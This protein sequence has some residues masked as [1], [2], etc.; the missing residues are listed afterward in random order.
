[1]NY[2]SYQP[3]GNG[4]RPLPRPSSSGTLSGGSTLEPV[5]KRARL[6][7]SPIPPIVYPPS[8]QP[9]LVQPYHVQQPYGV[10][11]M[12]QPFARNQ[13]SPEPSY[14]EPVQAPK[15]QQKPVEDELEEEDDDENEE[16]DEDKGLL[17]SASVP[18]ISVPGTSITLNT[19][20]DITKWREE[21]KKMWL[22]KISNN[23]L[24][25]MQDM[26]IQEDEL[27][28]HRGPL[29]DAK[30][31]KQF[32]QSIQSQVSRINPR[33]TLSVRVAQREMA[34]DNSKLLDFI[35]KLGD[36]NLLTYE[37]TESEKEKLFGSNNQNDR[38]ERNNN[39]PSFRKN[40][41]NKNYRHR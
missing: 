8:S 33:S 32:L 22:L 20:E 7:Q 4:S 35:E 15:Q 16:E 29:Q 14:R 25:H 26:G 39:T 21:R 3:Y 37:L 2:H 5:N 24:K 10:P 27:K 36:S 40:F 9:Y 12:P 19:M 18:V 34:R 31:Q 30:K 1:M 23:K 17:D 11:M 38:R 13:W 6:Q 28:G 41:T